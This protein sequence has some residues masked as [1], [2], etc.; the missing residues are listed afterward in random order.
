MRGLAAPQVFPKQNHLVVP[1][2]RAG[3]ARRT[4]QMAE[5]GHVIGQLSARGSGSRDGFERARA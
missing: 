5:V 1:I 2:A 3:G 4:A